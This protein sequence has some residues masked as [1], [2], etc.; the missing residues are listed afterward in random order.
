LQ[1]FA[2]NRKKETPFRCFPLNVNVSLGHR[3]IWKGVKKTKTPPKCTQ[4][5]LLYIFACGN[6]N[7]QQT[8]TTQL[9]NTRDGNT[10][11]FLSS[12]CR[13]TGRYLPGMH[14][15]AFSEGKVN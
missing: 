13:T 10:E 6:I 3:G 1:R 12:D 11:G 5:R 14:E 8:R 7:Y 9:G 4:Q 15:D 2:S